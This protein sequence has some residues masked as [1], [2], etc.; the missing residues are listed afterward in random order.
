[1]YHFEKCR[2]FLFLW[3]QKPTNQ[4]VMKKIIFAL[5]LLISGQI[6]AQKNGDKI[7]IIDA[8]GIMNANLDYKFSVTPTDKDDLIKQ[9]GDKEYKAFEKYLSKGGV[10]DGVRSAYTGTSVAGDELYSMTVYQIATWGKHII[11]KVPDKENPRATKYYNGGKDMYFVMHDRESISADPFNRVPLPQPTNAEVEK[12]HKSPFKR[13]KIKSA[14]LFGEYNLPSGL[15]GTLQTL[16]GDELK[17]L[18]YDVTFFSTNYS[19]FSR[20]RAT[21]YGSSFK[22]YVAKNAVAYEVKKFDDGNRKDYFTL[23]KIP[24]DVNQHFPYNI[25]PSA[26]NG[27]KDIYF[28][29][30]TSNVEEYKE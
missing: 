7:R 29:V 25:L 11:A 21:Y 10:P 24:L 14:D 12:I 27:N 3:L 22:D 28:I 2:Q 19:F 6:A 8:A 13:V 20:R 26:G 17:D 4:I 23:V 30:W 5:F 9:M 16:Y 1:L 15:T 18:T